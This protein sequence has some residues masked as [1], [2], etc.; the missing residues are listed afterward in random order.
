MCFERISPLAVSVYSFGFHSSNLRYFPSTL[1]K[2]AVKCAYLKCGTINSECEINIPPYNGGSFSGIALILPATHKCVFYWPASHANC[3]LLPING[4][5]FCRLPLEGKLSSKARLMR[6]LFSLVHS[7]TFP[8][9]PCFATQNTPSPQG[10]GFFSKRFVLYF[11][12]ENQSSSS[13][14]STYLPI[15]RLTSIEPRDYRVVFVIQ[16]RHLPNGRCL[17]CEKILFIK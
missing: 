3:Y 7:V 17:F 9:H 2:C 14:I 15:H 5:L 16:K 10:E 12:F 1:Q 6:C 4:L 11:H 13:I 8:P